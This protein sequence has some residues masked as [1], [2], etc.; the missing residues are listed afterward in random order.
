MVIRSKVAGVTATNPDGLKRQEIIRRAC[1]AGM[2][3]IAEREPKNPY[4]SNAIGLWI[5]GKAKRWQIGYIKAGLADKLSEYLNQGAS[6]SVQ[7]LEVTGGDAG[8]NFGVNIRID[9]AGLGDE[10]KR[11]TRRRRQRST[12]TVEAPGKGWKAIQGVG[13]LGVIAGMVLFGIGLST[14]RAGRDRGDAALGAAGMVILLLSLPIW[15][16]GRIGAWWFHG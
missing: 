16:F 1:H 14:I 15:L 8:R 2:D 6:L 4:D 11:R 7:I 3:L 10:P 5:E 13:C 9:V 12:V